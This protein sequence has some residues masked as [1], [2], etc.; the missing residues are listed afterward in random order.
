MLKVGD[1]VKRRINSGMGA[2]KEALP[3]SAWGTVIFV[4][5]KGRFHVVEFQG[6]SG[7]FRESFL[8]LEPSYAGD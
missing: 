4:H 8:G 7:T 3:I 6:V 5:P 2:M 1:K